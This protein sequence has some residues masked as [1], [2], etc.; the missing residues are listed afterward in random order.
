MP[1]HEVVLKNLSMMVT[2]G[3]PTRL[4]LQ[5]GLLQVLEYAHGLEQRIE[6]LEAA[7]PARA[8]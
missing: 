7:L 2:Y 4:D 1:S 8:E 5:A 3:D 6:A